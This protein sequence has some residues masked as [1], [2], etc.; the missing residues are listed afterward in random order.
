MASS[1]NRQL[2]TLM[3]AGA[4]AGTL[5]ALAASYQAL[6]A[7]NKPKGA[8]TLEGGNFL[9][10]NML[11]ISGYVRDFA[12]HEKMLEAHKKH[13]KTFVVLL[14]FTPPIVNTTD[15]KIVEHILKTNFDN[16][17]KGEWFREMLEELL[18]QGIFNADGEIWH[19]Q[20]KTAS[21]M[22]TASQFKNHI[23]SVV[24]KSSASLK[25]VMGDLCNGQVVD[26]FNL[27]NRFTLDTIGAVG[28]ASDIGSL[29]KADSPFLKSFDRAQ[30]LL[31]TR[32]INPLWKVERYLNIG[33]ER[34]VK[35]HIKTL[36]DYAQKIVQDLKN[37][38]TGAK[39]DS[40]VGMFVAD[41]KKSGK[42]IDDKFLQDMV[43]NFLIAGRD[44]TAQSMSWIMYLIM[45][46][47]EVEKKILQELEEELGISDMTYEAAGRLK[48][49]QNVVN[50]GLR[51]YP[52]VPSD[53]KVCLNDDTLPDG[54][55]IPKGTV[56]EYN[57]YSMGRS[58]ELW[59]EDAEE[60]KPER[61]ENR[62]LPSSYVYTAFNA[63]PRECLGK[64]LA[65]VEMK[66][67]LAVM[68]RNFK[69]EL[70]VPREEIKMDSALTIGMSSG[71]PCRVSKRRSN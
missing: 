24:D 21:H 20:R 3:K 27:L 6:A 44:T 15:P 35:V 60:F 23:W 67:G 71:L 13:G 61:W 11:Q 14:P 48:Y 64:R 1:S 57:P 52:S 56:I 26:V 33:S 4:A 59:G 53:T 29:K 40:F 63:G 41:S 19:H 54:T 2:D 43:L 32:F 8:P 22:F 16:Y 62:Q 34:E 37:D 7:K 30:Q 50:E 5:V 42:D 66:A 69:F 49:L 65:W 51:L 47:P 28:F 68:L 46:H 12:Y 39:L 10:G 25:Q 9:L 58:T 17:P 18:G 55:W 36:T 38:P 70:A 31:M 45:G